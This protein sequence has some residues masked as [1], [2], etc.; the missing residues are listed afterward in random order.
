MDMQQLNNTDTTKSFQELVAEVIAT[1]E[2]RSLV[3]GIA[4]EVVK[5]W[6]G[7]SFIKKPI[8]ASIGKSIEK[9][10]TNDNEIASAVELSS[11]FNNSDF[12]KKAG[13]ELPGLING[14]I[15]ALATTG[16]Y[17]ETLPE[18]DRIVYVS[19][20][21]SGLNTGTIAEL[22]TMSGRILNGM[23]EENPE[24]LTELLL[25]VIEEWIDRTDFGELRD[26]FTH[27]TGDFTK[28]T[29]LF[30]ESMCRYP[31]KITTLACILPGLLNILVHFLKETLGQISTLFMSPDMITD[32]F[33]G[34]LREVDGRLIGEFINVLTEI[35]RQWTV[36]SA[37]IG[38]PGT[39]I[40][41]RDI[42]ALIREIVET[43]DAETFNKARKGMAEGKETVQ[44][45]V[46]EI[47]RNNPELL[48]GYLETSNEIRNLAVKGLGQKIEMIEDIP[49]EAMT[50]TIIQSVSSLN[51]SDLAEIVNGTFRTL[52]R[53]WRHN[54]KFG[55]E[56]LREFTNGLDTDEMAE[57]A[58]W[59]TD[60]L[61][62]ALKPVVRALAPHMLTMFV[63]WG[64]ANGQKP[65]QETAANA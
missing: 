22:V 3:G 59:V 24:L 39:P 6:A 54:P 18:K 52:N 46:I 48:T 33:L 49:D 11:L 42:S 34:L 14:L 45:A 20:L 9:G 35:A 63:S 8:A 25:P 51:T 56:F 50:E 31:A 61:G 58:G 47:L 43:V 28:L 26:T 29:T 32:Y 15:S 27:F 53:M 19:D 60:D 62:K 5:I 64:L 21:L 41:I 2:M 44:R 4:P 55:A 57:T 38:E 7:G 16:S 10:F 65:S 40:F 17:L 30:W 23:Y 36:G 37:L 12:L 1:K 13:G